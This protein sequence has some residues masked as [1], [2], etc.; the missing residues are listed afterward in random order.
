MFE[1]VDSG[2]VVVVV[3]EN[4]FPRVSDRLTFSHVLPKK[5][6]LKCSRSTVVDGRRHLK[7]VCG[8][9]GRIQLIFLVAWRKIEKALPL[10]AF[11]G[12]S[13][14]RLYFTSSTCLNSDLVATSLVMAQPRGV[15]VLPVEGLHENLHI[16]PRRCKTRW[17]VLSFWM[18]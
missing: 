9:W 13:S 1:R 14:F 2:L 7:E 15:M 5:S 10:F 12:N 3:C 16:P 18:F 17:R 6:Q 8:S 11:M 4:D